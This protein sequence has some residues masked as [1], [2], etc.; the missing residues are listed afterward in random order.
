MLSKIADNTLS[1]ETLRGF[2]YL[3]ERERAIIELSNHDL[4]DRG[5]SQTTL[6]ELGLAFSNSLKLTSTPSG[7]SSNSVIAD[8]LLNWKEEDPDNSDFVLEDG[9]MKLIPRPVVE[10]KRTISISDAIKNFSTGITRFAKRLVPGRVRSFLLNQKYRKQIQ[11]SKLFDSNWYLE[12]YPDVN[13][14][15]ADPISHYLLYGSKE[16]RNPGPAFDAN[17]YWLENNDVRMTR[18]NPLIH[19]INFGKTEG[20]K[21]Y[22]VGHK[23]ENKNQVEPRQYFTVSN[24]LSK[25]EGHSERIKVIRIL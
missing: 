4:V 25:I 21:I 24:P 7:S 8:A 18:Q 19:Y 10:K 5:Y 15:K 6:K 3:Y 11:D 23:D 1:D 13:A 20:R 22:P 2:A 17:R 9:V 14:S 16:G 12:N